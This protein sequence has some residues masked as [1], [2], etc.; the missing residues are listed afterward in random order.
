V[1]RRD[2]NRGLLPNLRYLNWSFYCREDCFA[3]CSTLGPTVTSIQLH[4]TVSRSEHLGS[5]DFVHMIEEIQQLSPGLTDLRCIG[6]INYEEEGAPNAALLDSSLKLVQSQS[7]LCSLTIDQ[8][9]FTSMLPSL[10]PL[11]QLE[12]LEFDARGLFRELEQSDFISAPAL[13][14]AVRIMKGD[15][16]WGGKRFWCMFLPFIGHLLTTIELG[17]DRENQ[18]LASEAVELTACIGSSC[19]YM[20]TLIISYMAHNGEEPSSLS[21]MFRGLLQCTM[22]AKVE[23]SLSTFDICLTLTDADIKD[24]SLAWKR[25]EILHLSAIYVGDGV[26]RMRSTLT[27]DAI[28]ILCHHCPRLRSLELTVDASTC[29]PILLIRTS[30]ALQYLQLGRSRVGDFCEVAGW[31]GNICFAGSL[32]FSRGTVESEQW[33]NV[34]KV[35]RALELARSVKEEEMRAELVELKKRVA[36][37]ET[38]VQDLQL[39]QGV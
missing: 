28:A 32:F 15:I 34:E 11:F 24:M 7:A 26:V 16:D 35:M 23:I 13:L 37:L 21:G 36:Q 8:E 10:R 39:K 18:I 19:P 3:F 1:Y 30:G 2:A 20:E 4:L 6:F 17:N 38:V 22:L 12:T 9:L 29:P 14:P 27:L 5:P 33:G 25:L 31:L